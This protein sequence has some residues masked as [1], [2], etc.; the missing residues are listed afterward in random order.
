VAVGDYIEEDQQLADV[1]TDKA[2][3]E[4]S[5]PVS[6]KIVSLGCEAGEVLAVGL[7]LVSFEVEST[8]AGSEE[9]Q[10]TSASDIP[11]K[12]SA[13]MDSGTVSEEDSTT[14]VLTSPSV[15]RAARKLNIDLTKVTGTGKNSR[16][17]NSDLIAYQNQSQSAEPIISTQT[18]LAYKEK[19][20]PLSGLRKVIANKML[21]SKHSIPHYSYIEEIDVT[22]IE[23][24]RVELNETRLEGRV[25]LTIL[26]F[27]MQALVKVLPNYP[28]CN[29][30]FDNET[31][32]LTQFERVNIGIAT[33]TPKGL[34]VPV[35]ETCQEKNI[36]DFSSEISTLASGAREGKLASGRLKRS[37]ITISSLGPIGGIATTP[38]INAPET[39][40]IGVNKIIERPVVKDGE[41][42]FKKIM[43]LSS[44]FDHRIVD[45]FDGASLVQSIKYLLENP[46]KLFIPE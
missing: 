13:D 28:H 23:K 33:M 30:W 4:V 44:S 15:R 45:G 46:M 43:N 32:Q 37:T 14:L 18:E 34:M 6:G 21:D 35:V 42:Q 22:D 10:T 26:P 38:I 1:M 8:T 11:V 12:S 41:L 29:G 17:N 20:I 7:E 5:S 40:T 31:Q 27:I 25:K 2:V 39:T 19:V 16:I 36:W 9:E 3:V 24:L